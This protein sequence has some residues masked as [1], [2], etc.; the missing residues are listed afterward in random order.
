MRNALRRLSAVAVFSACAASPGAPP[1]ARSDPEPPP[2]VVDALYEDG[3]RTLE[4]AALIA[5]VPLAEGEATKVALV[6]A[7]A[8]SS[9]HVVALR[10]AEPLHRHDAHDLL[11]VLLR[12]HGRMWIEGEER[13]IGPDSITF[14]PRG[15][16]HSLRN[17]AAEPLVGYVVF[18]PP[19]DGRDRVLVEP[20]AAAAEASP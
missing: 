9:H 20:E 12:G 15:A 11:A 5:S 8:H 3:R 16:V 13:T 14:V 19:F 6:G 1:G 18:W 7:D 2:R 4:P 17:D 10:D